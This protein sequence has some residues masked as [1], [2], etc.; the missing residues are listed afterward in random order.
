MATTFQADLEKLLGLNQVSY[1]YNLDK[2]TL[3]H[4]AIANDRGRVRRGGPDNEQKAFATSLGDKG[5]LMFYTDPDCTGRRTK[6]TFAVKWPEVA[7]EIWFKA[8]LNPFEP[9]KY[10]ALLK[11]V[12]QHLNDKHASLYVKDVFMGA[13]PSFTVPYRFVGEFATHAMFVDNMF[14]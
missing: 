12:V 9:E 3:F 10:E 11:R 6:D 13:D 1:K 2:T 8:D 7:D 4:E 5:P 14:P